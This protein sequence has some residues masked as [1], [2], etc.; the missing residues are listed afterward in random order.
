[1]PNE[2]L[3]EDNNVKIKHR[4]ITFS[5]FSDTPPF[6]YVCSNEWPVYLPA[7]SEV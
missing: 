6:V 5:L 2:D 4:S 1:M 7:C 3:L